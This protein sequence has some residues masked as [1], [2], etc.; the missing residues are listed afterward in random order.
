[1]GACV[2]FNMTSKMGSPDIRINA[3]QLRRIGFL[4]SREVGWGVCRVQYILYGAYRGLSAY[5][6]KWSIANALPNAQKDHA[7]LRG[8][9]MERPESLFWRSFVPLIARVSA[10]FG[11]RH[12]HAS[13]CRRPFCCAVLIATRV[14]RRTPTN[15]NNQQTTSRQPKQTR[16]STINSP[17]L[18]TH[19]LT[20]TLLPCPS[21]RCFAGIATTMRRRSTC[22]A[23]YRATATGAVVSALPSALRRFLRGRTV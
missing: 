7:A 16:Q 4:Y 3:G 15:T 20:T 17:L 19:T 22:S 14:V 8:G 21:P 1:M 2:A 6:K 12:S 23:L 9:P 18:W 5:P 10:R 11:G 13:R